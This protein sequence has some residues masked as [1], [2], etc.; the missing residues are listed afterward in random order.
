MELYQLFEFEFS[1]DGKQFTGENSK[2][3]A[4]V[5]I[6]AQAVVVCGLEDLK[7]YQALWALM[8]FNYISEHGH[9]K[10]LSHTG[11][12]TVTKVKDKMALM[13][14][15]TH[16]VPYLTKEDMSRDKLEDCFD[17]DD[18]SDDYQPRKFQKPTGRNDW[19]EDRY[20]DQV[21]DEIFNLVGQDECL[22]LTT[23][24]SAPTKALLQKPL[25]DWGEDKN[26]MISHA[27]G[28][29]PETFGTPE[30]MEADRRWLARYN[31]AK[32]IQKLANEEFDERR[33]EILSWVGERLEANAEAL[34]NAAVR[35]T[36]ITR[37]MKRRE[38]GHFEIVPD[39]EQEITED[40]ILS[41]KT[42]K[43]TGHPF[44][45]QGM[46]SG[47]VNLYSWRDTR[48]HGC[49]VSG[50]VA[51]IWTR[52]CPKNAASLA[53]LMGCEIADMPD[54]LRRWTRHVNYTGNSILNRLDPMDCNLEDPWNRKLQFDVIL[55]LSKSTF[56]KLL[57]E[58]G[59]PKREIEQ[60][61]DPYAY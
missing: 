11:S 32:Y 50:K 26:V 39:D 21:P 16:E 24:E 36:F 14:P 35:G 23:G 15:G 41:Q 18:A 22:Q 52:F 5:P 25:K 19:L 8:M 59:L 60:G 49:H 31:K 13:V 38:A 28:V 56:N 47:R 53:A 57:K 6:N 58:Q 12:G 45:Y 46:N 7:P 2:K 17:A 54:V 30:Q 9:K 44:G 20:E 3:N 34:V 61:R 10:K 27:E 37:T 4:L 40:E 55:G 42:W 29:L 1:D 51:S 43:K 48:H 33:D